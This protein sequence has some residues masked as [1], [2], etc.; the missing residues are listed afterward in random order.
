MMNPLRRPIFL[1]SSEAGN[2]AVMVPT[3]FN[4]K[5]KCCERFICCNRM[6]HQG[7]CRYGQTGDGSGQGKTGCNQEKA[8]INPW[9]VFIHEL[10]FDQDLEVYLVPN[11][12]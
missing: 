8:E 7:A 5:W 11:P 1:I 12:S 6:A 10:I 4:T 3:S 9:I 2:P